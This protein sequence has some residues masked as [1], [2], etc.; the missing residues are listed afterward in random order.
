MK[1]SMP[2]DVTAEPVVGSVVKALAILRHLAEG[3]DRCGVNAIAMAVSLNPSSCFNIVKTL[4]RG[5]RRRQ[6]TAGWG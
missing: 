4:V 3:P 6:A 5:K 2:K 1:D